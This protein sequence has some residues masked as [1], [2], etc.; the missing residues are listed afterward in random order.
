VDGI[1]RLLEIGMHDDIRVFEL[2]LLPNAP[3]S[4]PGMRERYGLHTRFKPIRLTRTGFQREVVE[5]VFG[6]GS[7]PYAT[8]P[9]A[10]FLPR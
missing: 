10:C 4:Q 6:T 2:A 9:T 8:G 7:M 3:L 1:C 5:L